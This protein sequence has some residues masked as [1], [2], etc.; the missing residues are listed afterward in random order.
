MSTCAI[1]EDILYVAD[2]EG[3]LHCLD[4]KTGKLHWIHDTESPSWS[5]PYYA[6]G[7]VY[8]GTDGS[9]VFVFA[10][11]KEKN[12]IAENAMKGRVR[13]TPVAANGV[14]YVMT[15]NKLYAIANKK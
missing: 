7:K 4:A 2:M 1:H 15:E 8:F 3:Y 9:N 10:H 6:D 12:L 13:A 5:S 11:G 14:L